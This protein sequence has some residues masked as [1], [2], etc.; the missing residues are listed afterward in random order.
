MPDEPW[1]TFLTDTFWP[2]V[3][4]E[5]GFLGALA[6]VLAVGAVLRMAVRSARS[7]G[8]VHRAVGLATAIVWVQVLVLSPAGPILNAPATAAVPFL[9]LGLLA[10]LGAGPDG[11]PAR[12]P[13]RQAAT[14]SAGGRP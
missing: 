4:G 7:A 8:P 9:L 13:A 10:R 2:A 12:P 6:Y 1:N 11:A 14:A 5:T 3:L